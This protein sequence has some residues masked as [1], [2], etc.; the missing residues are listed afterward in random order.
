MLYIKEIKHK[1]KGVFT[2]INIGM[3]ALIETC[4]VILFHDAVD[5]QQLNAT[6]LN[7]YIFSWDENNTSALALGFGSFYNHSQQSNAEYVMK[8]DAL[9]LEIYAVKDISAHTEITINY[10]GIPNGE[11]LEWFAKKG[12]QYYK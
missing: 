6:V 5:Q 12:I 8:H 7:E 1:G 2:T 10:T 11:S 4:P 9:R 3:G